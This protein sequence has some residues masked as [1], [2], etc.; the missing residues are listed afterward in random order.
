MTARLAALTPEQLDESQ[1]A[2]YEAVAGGDRARGTQHFPLTTAD[3]S[4][5]GPFGVMLHA[6]SVGMTLQQLGADI[7]F[8]TDLTSRIREIAILEVAHA[9][10]SHF[11]WWAHERVGRAVGLT[12]D[13][14][15]N[16]SLGSFSTDDPLES[17]AA[18]L[19]RNLLGSS[20][21]TDA[22]YEAAAAVLS[23]A[24]LIELTVLVGYYRT[25]AQ[26]MEV[27]AIGVPEESDG[28][29]ATHS[30]PSKESTA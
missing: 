26:L 7:R 5:N 12:D 1:R 4:L 10:G 27:F 19:C 2:I 24:Q 23:A 9:V 28:L 25:L 13:E 29:V 30:E 20:V 14:I 17:A 6:P 21:V 11:E 16:L 18:A 3:G 22:E 15:T 8:R